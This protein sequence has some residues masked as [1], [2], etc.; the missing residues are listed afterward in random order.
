MLLSLNFKYVL[1][2]LDLYKGMILVGVKLVVENYPKSIN[3]V[4]GLYQIIKGNY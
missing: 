4:P 2:G 3:V 1:K